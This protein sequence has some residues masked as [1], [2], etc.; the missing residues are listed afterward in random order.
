ME[1]CNSKSAI[2]DLKKTAYIDS[3][4]NREFDSR[5]LTSNNKENEKPNNTQRSHLSIYNCLGS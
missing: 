1:K 3:F 5:L 4:T 2:S